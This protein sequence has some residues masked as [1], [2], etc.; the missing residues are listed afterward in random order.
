VKGEKK[1]KSKK[2]RPTNKNKPLD[3]INIY[4]ISD[5]LDELLKVL[6]F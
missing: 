3:R 5:D 2:K 4:E 1:R 6:V